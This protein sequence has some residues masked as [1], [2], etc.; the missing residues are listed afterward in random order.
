M[1]KPFFA[2]PYYHDYLSP[3]LA[4]HL[5]EQAQLVPGV[6][7][8]VEVGPSRGLETKEALRFLVQLYSEV[9]IHLGQVLQ[10]R[11]LDRKFMDER[12][13]ACHTFNQDLGRHWLDPDYQTIL[14]LED[15]K[16]RVVIGP[17]NSHYAHSQG[18]P[19]APLPEFLKGPHVTLFG[20]PDTRKMSI[21]A[22]NAFHRRLPNEPPLVAEL[23]AQDELSPM[24]G[25]DDEDSKTPLRADLVSA[26]ENLTACFAG[27]IAVDEGERKYRL[28]GERL[29]QPIKRFPGLALPA[30]FLFHENQPIPLHLYDFALHLFH[31]W[32]NPKALVFYVPKLES[33]EE[34]IYLHHLIQAA[35]SQIHALHPSYPKGRVRL[36]VVLENPRA[37]LRVHEI[38][39]ALFPYFAGASLGWHDYL[40]STARVF[41]E[42]ANYRIPVKADPDIVIKY[43]QASH[44]LLADTVGARGGIKVGGMYGILPLPGH[45]QSLQV[46]LKGFI[47]DVVTQLKRDLTGFWV[48]HPDFV[49]LGLA[50][51]AAWRRCQQGA[52]EVL[53][54]LV[55]ALLDETHHQE[56]LNFIAGPDSEGWD[57]ADPHYV[58]S[59]LVADIAESDFIPNNHPEEI[60]YNVFQ[61]LQYLTDWLS[62]NGCV[63]LPTVI[64][65]TPVRVMDDLATAERSRW[66]VWHEIHHGR[67]AV[68]DFLCIVHE[69]LNFIRRDLSND[70]KIV[71]VKWDERTQKWYPIAKK[72]MLQLMLS[73]KP[74][75]FATE[76]LLPFT[77]ESIRSASDPWSTLTQMESHKYELDSYITQFDHY[78]EIC[79]VSRFAQA[80]ADDPIEEINK[81]RDLILSFSMAE[82]QSAA[83]FHGDIGQGKKTL[84]LR[85]SQEQALVLNEEESVRQELLD[86]GAAYLTRFGF[87]FLISAKGRSALEIREKLRTR[88]QQTPEQELEQARLAL[89]EIARHRLEGAP[90]QSLKNI[91]A[92]RHRHGIVGAAVAINSRGHT[93]VLCLGESVK[94]QSPIK[95]ETQF[96]LASLSK[97]IATAFALEYLREKK[98]PLTTSVNSLLAQ[99]KSSFRL[100]CPKNPN[101]A[102][103]VQVE[104]LL[105]HTA[106][107]LHYV[108]GFSPDQK[109]PHLEEL[110]KGG[111]G[112]EAAEVRGE[113]GQTFQYS[114]GGFLVL[115]H[116]LEFM[117]GE[118]LEPLLRKFLDRLGLEDLTFDHEQN[119][120]AHGYFAS[121]LSRLNF[122]A[123]AAGGFGTSAAMARFLAILTEAYHSLAGAHGLSHETAVEMLHGKDRGAREFMGCDMGL[124]VFIAEAGPNRLAI[125][126]GA[127]EGFRTLYLQC[128]AG[129]DQGKGFVV[130]C[131]GDNAGVPFVAEVARELLQVLKIQGVQLDQLQKVFA[132]QGV[133]PEQIVNQGYKALL[134]NAFQPDLPEQIAPPGPVDPL[135]KYNLTVTAQILAVSNQKFGRAANLLSPC[136]PVFDPELFGAQGKIMDSWESARHNSLGIDSLIMALAAPALIRYLSLSTKFHDGNHP[137]FVQVL[138]RESNGPWVELIPKIEVAGHS[139]FFLKLPSLPSV[140][141]VKVEIYPDGGLTRLGLYAELPEAAKTDFLSVIKWIRFTEPVPKVAKPL[142]LPYNS[143]AKEVQK[144]QTQSQPP[145]NWAS[146]ALGAQLLRASNEHYG[147]AHQVISPFPPLHMF[148]G[149][150]SARSRNLGHQEQVEFKLGR[151]TVIGWVILDFSFFVNNNPV[152]VSVVGESDGQWIELIPKSKV[153]AFAGNQCRFEIS[154]P[155]TFSK[156]RVVVYPDGGVHRIKVFEPGPLV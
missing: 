50:V 104:H 63:A 19:I 40:A 147:P 97:T 15:G 20:P 139:R 17:K 2:I 81:A 121:S 123:F 61:S 111:H 55:Q 115:E 108:R 23:L 116:L 32:Q 134:F 10:Q 48:A 24:W 66:E 82:I 150:E 16:G 43:I 71:Q 42:D 26:G 25:A 9:K 119:R 31:N 30:P 18:A 130:L 86:L 145:R 14:G 127:N 156:I 128:Y 109:M 58:R 132:F 5:L 75:E 37:I 70:K 62:G 53:N 105:N 6:E 89:W 146:A 33:E 72:I 79:G 78:F 148:D 94:G 11:I 3:A 65:D 68:E 44:R 91:E 22:M 133:A 151:P 155:A 122:P 64:N 131:N 99:T 28:A 36:M 124:G 21:N 117:A 29:A 12:V 27:T 144:N 136:L 95:S 47:K 141:Q 118:P 8:L 101:W 103:Q 87:K 83:Q 100:R 67:F 149:L 113:P 46:T 39:D 125:H 106:L 135:A 41:K 51:V 114:G 152:F 112:Y 80:L 92:A 93:Q 120:C 129:P 153:K 76:L 143:T 54:K 4:Q 38:M 90:Q 73:P 142:T 74:V 35:E 60:R 126:Q 154:H 1:V 102:D 85:A 59:L 137:E 96:E 45:H 84:D 57:V 77:I 34:A 56:V 13:R 140:S 110:L 138:G 7:N 52:P 107:N 49:R 88:L 98:I 69:E